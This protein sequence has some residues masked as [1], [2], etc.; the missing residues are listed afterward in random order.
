MVYLAD[1]NYRTLRRDK[2]TKEVY[3]YRLIER[4]L[5][6]DPVFTSKACLEL[7]RYL[8]RQVDMRRD[9]LRYSKELLE[10]PDIYCFLDELPAFA[11]EE[12]GIM[13]VLGKLLREARQYGIFIVC[14]AQ[15]LLNETLNSKNGAIRDNFLTC[16]Y[17]GGDMTTGRLI[18]NIPKE[19]TI[20]EA[21]LGE[22][23]VCYVRAKGAHVE[24]VKGRT[25]LADQLATDMLL[26][27]LPERQKVVPVLGDDLP[28]HHGKPVPEGMRVPSYA[29]AKDAWMAGANSVVKLQAATKCTHHTATKLRGQ[30]VEHGVIER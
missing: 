29:E 16:F 15:D 13:L 1:Y 10:F 30:L 2:V 12:K 3:D 26:A 8:Y 20:D 7:L 18:L 28:P 19:E 25:P 17:G 27:G 5:A 22:K 21:G 6:G 9:L 11:G 4:Q 24:R 14:A 23:G